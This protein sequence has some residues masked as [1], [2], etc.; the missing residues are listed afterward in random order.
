MKIR[1]NLFLSVLM[2]I[3]CFD[4]SVNAMQA[5]APS[6]PP[7]SRPLRDIIMYKDE[8]NQAQVELMH[9]EI[10]DALASGR[11]INERDVMCHDT[12]LHSL[13]R[14]SQCE[15]LS[16][17]EL[18]VCN[19]AMVNAQNSDYRTPLHCAVEH[20]FVEIIKLLLGKGALPFVWDRLE[21]TPLHMAVQQE[22]LE[23]STLFLEHLR[24]H[25]IPVDIR[26][27]HLRTPLHEAVI[28]GNLALVK[29][30]IAYGANVNER[31]RHGSTPLH[32]AIA[33]NRF[34]L[35]KNSHEQVII[36]LIDARA[37]PNAQDDMGW[38]PLHWACFNM[39][40]AVCRY[41]FSR[42]AY[43]NIVSRKGEIP[44]QLWGIQKKS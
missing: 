8:T 38:T 18:L 2:G 24:S 26:G 3:S 42:G 1:L 17:V 31:D 27:A 21:Q 4:G 5:L 32:L 9:Q 40:H 23:I 14:F 39:H 33:Y 22:K 28:T 7:V 41:L 13:I 35:G 36:E 34:E 12:P 11:D 44:A 19:G 29:L 30:L 6:F 10:L 25:A 37:F 16:T 20:G 15:L 43:H